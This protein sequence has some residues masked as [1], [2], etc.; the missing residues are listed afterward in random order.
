MD[1][2]LIILSSVLGAIVTYLI[3]FHL[4]K[5]V[6]FGSALVT[7]LSGIFYPHFFSNG[8]TLAA[9]S[10]CAS[11][12]AMVSVEKFPKWWEMVGVGLI[13]GCIFIATTNVFVGV[14]GRLGAIAA[15]SGFSW[16]GMKRVYTRL[17]LH[18]K[19]I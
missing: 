8:L 16:L 7:L 1:S 17:K 12:A 6:V 4:N 19:E 13:V 3:S 9:V 2:L 10:T 15:I 18:K 11:Y 14:G 5:G